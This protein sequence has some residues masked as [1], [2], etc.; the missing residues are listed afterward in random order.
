LFLGVEIILG[1]QCAELVTLCKGFV[2]PQRLRNTST[3][4]LYI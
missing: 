2:E 1:R 3:G 4:L